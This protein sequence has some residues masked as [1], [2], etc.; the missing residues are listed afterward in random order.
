MLN[1][2]RRVV[3]G[4]DGSA[5]S[6]A[7]LRQ[8][9]G[10]ARRHHAELRPVLVYSSPQGDYI[11]MMWPPDPETARELAHKAHDDLM[12]ACERAGGLPDDVSCDPVVARGQAGPLLVE[13][14]TGDGDLLVVGSSSH[15]AV[16][17]FLMGSVSR[18]CLRHAP[19]PVLVI[20]P[21]DPAAH[22]PE[23]TADAAEAPDDA[24][25]RLKQVRSDR[26]PRSVHHL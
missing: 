12:G 10:E 19:G 21:E 6:I 23:Q 1:S 4:V 2:V 17:R 3:V 9:T 18:Y 13:A 14:A 20:P 22:G 5:G 11:D 15:H 26:A 8:A 16:H 24:A 7:A 25:A